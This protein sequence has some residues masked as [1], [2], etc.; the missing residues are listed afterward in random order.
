MAPD[1]SI[2]DPAYHESLRWLYGLSPN[3]RTAAQIVADHPRK[4]T[5]MAALLERIGRPDRRLQSVLVAGTKGK[6]SISAC[7]ESI[8][9]AA[10]L[11]A[12]LITSPHLVSWCERTR[13]DGRDID[14]GTVAPTMAN[15]RAAVDRLSEELPELGQATTFE[16]GLA[17]SL[18]AF[19]ERGVEIAVVEAGVGG[20]HD[21]TNVLD[22]LAVALG[23]ISYDHTA[24]LGPTL[25]A[26]AGEKTGIFRPGRLAIS[27]E[28]PPEALIVVERAARDRGAVLEL[29]GQTW[30]WHAHQPDEG[31]PCRGTFTVA[32]PRGTYKHLATP[33]LGRHQRENATMAVALTTYAL[34]KHHRS[35]RQRT[36]V[37]DD[38]GTPTAAAVREGLA[39]VRWPGRLQIL[40]ERPM[41][42]VDGAHNG[43]SAV[44]LAE[45]LRECFAERRRHLVL[46]MSV[47][48]DVSRMLDALLPVV[49]TVTL[50]RSHHDR[51]ASLEQL[52]QTVEARGI[53]ASIVPEVR[54]AVAQ[55][56]DRAE[57]DDLV[58]VT[59]SLFVVGEALEAHDPQMV[60]TT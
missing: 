60:K 42:V 21:A 54:D 20:L 40:R 14:P 7:S 44:R 17:F 37:G 51:S 36:P 16:A 46:G 49:S 33:L 19:A 56:L 10:G 57:P 50:T 31:Q 29:L 41:L 47:G 38:D 25:T 27:A 32:G 26:I 6:G 34:A 22:P 30:T 15:V 4:L 3:S 43:A 11:R 55:A 58:I 8:L 45:A 9:R 48:K 23:P 1:A 12:G 39:S 52:M 2:D 13:I 24:T 5:R 53:A 59:G 35:T 18:L 28:Q